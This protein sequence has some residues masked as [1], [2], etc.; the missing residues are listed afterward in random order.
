[1]Q[2]EDSRMKPSTAPGPPVMTST[3]QASERGQASAVRPD[4]AG[5]QAHATG[6][7]A[8]TIH[9]LLEA[10]PQGGGFKRGDDNPLDCDL[11][12]VDETSMVEEPVNQEMVTGHGGRVALGPRRGESGF[13]L[14][15]EGIGLQSILFSLARFSAIAGGALP[16]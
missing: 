11:L 14:I 1:V 16:S 12:V 15:F 3:M 8:K 2:H 5:S 4:R 6:F 10:D 13:W 9:R 7:E